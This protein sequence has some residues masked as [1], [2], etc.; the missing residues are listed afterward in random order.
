M[1]SRQYTMKDVA[2]EAGVSITTVSHVI[3]KTRFVEKET[4]KRVLKVIKNFK[5]TVSLNASSLR[6]KKTKLVGLIIPDVSDPVFSKL[7]R[8]LENSFFKKGY[9]LT[10]RN[11]E[12]NFEREDIY[13][14]G[15]IIA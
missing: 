4:E 14:Y 9:S 6:G 11:S 2:K 15:R 10:I 13:Q 8:D 5:Y 3:N 1:I 7:C 12:G